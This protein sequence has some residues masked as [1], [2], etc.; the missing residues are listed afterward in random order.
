MHGVVASCLPAGSK[1]LLLAMTG[2]LL[3]EVQWDSPGASRVTGG[4]HSLPSRSASFLVAALAYIPEI[5]SILCFY[6]VW[7][8]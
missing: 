3:L 6:L 7:R 2:A 8:R 1:F 4:G 5:K